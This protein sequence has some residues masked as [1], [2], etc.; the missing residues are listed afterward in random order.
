MALVQAL[1][2]IAREK[3]ASTAQLA[4]AWMR[5]RGDDVVPLVGA[6]RRDQLSEALGAI[7]MTLT[8]ADLARIAQAVPPEAVAGTRYLPAVLAHMD[9][10]RA[11]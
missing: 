4:F 6:R 10:E 3:N 7:E 11:G 8:P 9:S 1:A 5:S 2:A